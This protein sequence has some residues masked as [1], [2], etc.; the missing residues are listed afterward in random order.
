MINVILAMG[1]MTMC[2]VKV[3]MCSDEPHRELSTYSVVT[4]TSKEN[5]SIFQPI[6]VILQSTTLL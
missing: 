4:L 6:V 2:N 1:Q 3:T 5:V